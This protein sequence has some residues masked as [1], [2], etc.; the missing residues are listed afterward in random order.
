MI[1]SKRKDINMKNKF[2]RY[3][4]RN[5]NETA[6]NKEMFEVSNAGETSAATFI[7]KDWFHARWVDRYNFERDWFQ[8]NWI[9]RHKF[10]KN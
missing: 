8:K 9:Y 4:S 3:N 7:D 10:S 6:L 2:M 1:T 5:F